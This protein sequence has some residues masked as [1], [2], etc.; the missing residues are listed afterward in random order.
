MNAYRKIQLA[1]TAVI[2]NGLL[3]MGFS[4]PGPAFAST[5]G[6]VEVCTTQAYCAAHPGNNKYCPPQIGCRYAGQ[7]A[8]SGPNNSG[9]CTGLYSYVCFYL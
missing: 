9:P 4:S 5:C 6:P 2:A 1:A 8:C 7:V 3:A